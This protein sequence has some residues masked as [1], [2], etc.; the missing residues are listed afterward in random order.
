MIVLEARGDLFSSPRQTLVC[1]VNV[2]GVM[3]AGLARTFAERY[4]AVLEEYRRLF[5]VLSLRRINP[6]YGMRLATV[7]LEDGRQCL[8]FP[9]K[10]H[11]KDP[12]P[13]PLIASN[14][15][16]LARQYRE[17]NIQSLAMPAIGCGLGGLSWP[18]QVK[19][20]IVRT[21]HP[22]PVDVDLLV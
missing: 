18:L 7:P 9:T 1:P 21:L 13:L 11:W 15:A 22:L 17:L 19:P 14:L 20:L 8:L 2:V 16:L 5:P 3:G 12:S 4:P 10:L 6:R